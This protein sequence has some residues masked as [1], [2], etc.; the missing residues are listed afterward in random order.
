MLLCYY[1]PILSAVNKQSLEHRRC[2]QPLVLLFKYIEG[3]GPNYDNLRNS[4]HN[5]PIIIDIIKLA[6]LTRL[7][8]CGISFL[9]TLRDRLSWKLLTAAVLCHS[10]QKSVYQLVL[11]HSMRGR[12]GFLLEVQHHAEL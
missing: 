8:I 6:S 3:N 11:S 9:L 10:A 4:D 7:R 1:Y 2:Y 5:N 12:R